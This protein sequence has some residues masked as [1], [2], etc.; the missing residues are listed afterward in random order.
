M[1]DTAV[2]TGPDGA[3]KL[4]PYF[5]WI[6]AALIVSMLLS[7]LDQTIVSTALPTI[8]GDL[9]GLDEM[10]WVTTAYILAVTI[11]MPIYGKL[12]DLIGRRP[13]VLWALAIF[14]VG[15]LLSGFSQ[16]IEE[17]IAFRA[18]QGLGGGGLMICAQAIIADLVPVRQR[19]KYMGAIGAVFGLASV[20]G[21][22]LGGWI[23]DHVSWR[24]A[25]WIN[26]PLGVAAF[27]ISYF[28]IRLPRPDRKVKLDYLGT[29]VMALTVTSLVLVSDWGGND[30]AWTSPLILSLIAATVVGAITFIA[31]E[32]RAAEPLIPLYILRNRVFV[33]A[34]L[35][36]MIAVG[37]G[38]FA[39]ISY[40]PTY[41]QMVYGYS[42]TTS[43]LLMIPM[44]GGLVLTSRI[45]GLLISRFGRYKGFVITGTAVIPVGIYL[46]STLDP[47]SPVQLACVYLGILGLGVGLVM[48]NLL[49][50]V[51]NAFGHSEVGTATSSNN[52]F[53]EIGATVATATVGALFAGRITDALSGLGGSL[54]GSSTDSLT[55][56]LVHSLP[57][58]IRD[59]VVNAYA[60]S[61]LPIFTGLAAVALV[62]LALAFFLPN[63]KLGIDE[64]VRQASDAPTARTNSAEVSRR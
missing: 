6:Y 18:L 12:G 44:V 17:L 5:G 3:G 55:P 4:P 54:A 60:D 36:G 10:A 25:F 37:A 21:P 57:D 50:A 58:A 26:V 29:A 53:R 40:M 45:S 43:G 62:A 9:N 56:A 51:Q 42:A 27:A 28:G 24:W 13:L 32:R 20:A 33:V 63:R 31:V 41:L 34:I 39:V 19:A 59:Q 14:V 30:Y 38:M 52:F 47:S 48:Q 22:L 23:T 61:L 64:P 7:A 35:I 2:T 16:N 49:L 46:L 11:A 8:V 1:T 15:S